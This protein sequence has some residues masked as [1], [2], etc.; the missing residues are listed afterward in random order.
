MRGSGIILAANNNRNAGSHEIYGTRILD[1]RKNFH[2]DSL[3]HHNSQNIDPITFWPFY[4]APRKD[5]IQMS[6][7]FMLPSAR[8]PWK[9]KWK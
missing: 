1:I 9:N 4:I 5:R 8:Q 2:S 6:A 7:V 3:R